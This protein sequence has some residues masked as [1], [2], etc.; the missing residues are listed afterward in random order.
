MKK[1]HHPCEASTHTE[2]CNGKGTTKDHFTPRS[3]AN[4]WGW[5]QTEI[6]SPANIQYLSRQCHEAKD[7]TTARRK[8]LLELQLKGL[9][10]GFGKH[11]DFIEPIK[12][13][14]E[15]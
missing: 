10:V 4:L 1:E 2:G 5:K 14:N 9:F 12:K 6:E 8:M 3:I 11:N 7:K 15:S 13:N